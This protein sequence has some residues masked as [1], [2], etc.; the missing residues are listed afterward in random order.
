MRAALFNFKPPHAFVDKFLAER[1]PC[2][3]RPIHLSAPIAPTRD[4]CIALLKA[5]IEATIMNLG[6]IIGWPTENHVVGPFAAAAKQ[7]LLRLVP[8]LLP[9]ETRDGTFYRFVLEHGD[10]GSWNITSTIDEDE[11][12]LIT[13]MFDWDMSAVVPAI[14]SDLKLGVEIDLVADEYGNPAVSRLPYNAP[15]AK[16][17]QYKVWSHQYITVC[18]PLHPARD[19]HC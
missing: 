8:Y 14:F 18:I 13:S 2:S 9:P 1:V 6:D 17:V 10:F 3:F 16:R 11:K 5:K 12:P 19:K 7:S 15:A 4:F